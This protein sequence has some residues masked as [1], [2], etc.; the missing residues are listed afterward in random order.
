MARIPD[1]VVIDTRRH[2]SKMDALDRFNALVDERTK[3][4]MMKGE[5][6]DPFTYGN[7]SEACYESPTAMEEIGKFLR[8]DLTCQAGMLLRKTVVDYVTPMAR[9]YALDTVGGTL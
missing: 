7:I 8:A 5:R 9:D 3:D 4:L 6:F 1:S 2:E